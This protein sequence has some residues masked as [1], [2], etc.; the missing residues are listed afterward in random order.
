MKTE[1]ILAPLKGVTDAVYRTTFAQFFEGVDWAMAPFIST[2]RG[3]RIK[4]SHL[5]DILPENNRRLPVEPQIMS[6]TAQHFVSLA[7]AIYDMG[8]DTVNWNLGCPYPMVAKKMRGSGLLPHADKIAAFLEGV[9]PLLAGKLS[10]KMRLGRYQSDEIYKL[11]PMFD[12]FPLKAIT[13]HPRTGVQMY[14]GQ[15]D[16]DA[17]EHCLNMTR[18]TVIYNGDIV[19]RLSFDALRKR[20]PKVRFWMIGRWAISDPYLPGILKGLVDERRR[21]M[22]QFYR[23]HEALYARYARKLYGPSHLLNR[24]KGLWGYFSKAFEDGHQ[25]RKRIN[26]TQK[27][28]HYESVVEQFFASQ[29]QWCNRN[30][31]EG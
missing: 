17:F 11:L 3:P 15:T 1:I 23:F 13:I 6:K 25:W 24:M 30:A 28:H 19:D 16:L 27:T 31:D 20:F 5:S 12:D 10:I 4:P 22:E 7:S 21:P 2:T 18:H 8:Y 26:K 9:M 14:K 29:P